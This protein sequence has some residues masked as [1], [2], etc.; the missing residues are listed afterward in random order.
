MV[1]IYKN[2]IK[3][4]NWTI[5]F[6]LGKTDWTCFGSE[7]NYT[8]LCVYIHA[9]TYRCWW[10]LISNFQG[11]VLGCK[12]QGWCPLQ[13]S[14]DLSWCQPYHSKEAF[15]WQLIFSPFFLTPKHCSPLLSP[16]YFS[17]P[18]FFFL[19]SPSLSLSMDLSN[20]TAMNMWD[21]IYTW[22]LEMRGRTVFSHNPFESWSNLA[23][24]S[25]LFLPLLF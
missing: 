22:W 14:M 3:P 19:S 13:G 24:S 5:F 23:D 8:S 12:K 18:N 7:I 4:S 6:F 15:P 10:E 17:C 21:H 1:E 25:T 9:Y 11:H 2:K 16:H 20:S